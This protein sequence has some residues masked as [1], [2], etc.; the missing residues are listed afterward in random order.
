M[1]LTSIFFQGFFTCIGLIMVI[2]SQ[3]AFIL[4]HGIQRNYVFLIATI[5]LLG[6]FVLIGLGVNG[7]GALVQSSDILQLI[8]V[9]GGGGF[10]ITYGCFAFY[11]AWQ[12]KTLEVHV[13]KNPL[14]HHRNKLILLA[15]TF[16]LL[17]PHAWLDA[18]VILGSIGGQLDEAIE[19]YFFTFGALLGSAIWFY[20]LAFFA[21]KLAPVLQ[22][23][24]V[25][26]GINILVGCL[27]W[28][29]A[30]NLIEHYL[31]K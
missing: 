18:A 6:D 25:W 8:M 4:R 22:R 9:I 23:P 13:Q 15:L 14:V 21:W 31:S 5:S 29:I 24:R 28:A 17:N 7:L 30:Y 10:L 19:R 3:N 26:Q 16:S 12:K 11:S 27:M 20:G 1:S 2:G